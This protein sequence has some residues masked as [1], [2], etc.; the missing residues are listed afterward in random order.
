VANFY[1]FTG[2]QFFDNNG[3]PLAG[4]LISTFQAGGVIPQATFTDSTGGSPNTNP[5][6]CDSAGRTQIW[7]SP[8]SYK[9]VIKTAAGVTLQTLD[10]YNPANINSTV[11]SLTNT[12]NETLQQVTAATNLA[13]QSSNILEVDGSFWNGAAS[14]T[15]KWQI[16][17][18]LGAG[19]NPTSSLQ[20]SHSGSSGAA[21][22]SVPGSTNI[23][24][25]LTVGGTLGITGATT[26]AAITASGTVQSPLYQVNGATTGISSTVAARINI[27]NGT[28]GDASGAIL[29]NNIQSVSANHPTTGFVRVASAD[30]VIGYRNNANTLDLLLSKTGA[31]SSTAA[32]DTLDTSAFGSLKVS[33]LIGAGPSFQQFTGNGTFT[34]PTG[35]TKVTV[36]VVAGGGAGGGA[37][38]TNNGGGGGAGGSAI[39]WL[40]GLT[41]GN[42]LSVTVGA[43]GT[44]VSASAGNNGNVSSVASGTQTITTITTNGGG[45]GAGNGVASLGGFGG[46][47]GTGGDINNGGG[48]GCTAFGGSAT[49]VGAI[50]AGSIFGGGGN[51]TNAGAGAAATAPGGGGGGAGAAGNAAGGAG[52]AGVVIFEWVT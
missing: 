16:Q 18:V 17:D 41:P 42:T 5:V 49:A 10:N 14:A 45:G 28:S 39:K 40:S 27:G 2:F 7:L 37:T 29:L 19:T 38:A 34:I 6:V 50:G 9:L 35:I 23:G 48:G 46:V 31:A 22:L 4:G 12:G 15:D 33:A 47:A 20:V 24:T 26:A 25:N 11:T 21:L 44:G 30:S 51:N 36:T 1:L 3:A 32:A 8:A 52:A 13:N 43:G